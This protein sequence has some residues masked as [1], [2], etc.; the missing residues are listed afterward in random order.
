[1]RCATFVA[2]WDLVVREVVLVPWTHH[3]HAIPQPL[4]RRR[5][6]NEK[7]D[8]PTC[9]GD[10]LMVT[11]DETTDMGA[12]PMDQDEQHIDQG[13]DR[14]DDGMQPT[15]SVPSSPHYNAP[16]TP[17]ERGSPKGFFLA[18][19]AEEVPLGET[20]AERTSHERARRCM[21]KKVQPLINVTL[22]PMA[23]RDTSGILE[24]SMCDKRFT[25]KAA[26]EAHHKGHRFEG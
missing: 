8:E 18:S 12:E 25:S 14:A 1:M 3:R 10:E 24:C 4:F 7:G 2:T 9:A 20:E 6:K 16:P 21:P 22:G 5:Q 26:F 19:E 17:P 15:R 13:N 23:E 11:T